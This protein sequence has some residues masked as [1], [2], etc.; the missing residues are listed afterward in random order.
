MVRL[1]DDP[2]INASYRAER[3]RENLDTA[4]VTAGRRPAAEIVIAW[5]A[6]IC[7]CKSAAC[8]TRARIIEFVGR[9]T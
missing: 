8:G 6:D 9:D 4:S 2:D 3:H 7:G 1:H 5:H